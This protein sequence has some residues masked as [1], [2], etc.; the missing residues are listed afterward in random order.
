M[1]VFGKG[2][3]FGED[4]PGNRLV[5]HLSGCNMRCKWCSNPNGFSP[6]AG[7]RVSAEEML[8]E[9][10]SCK[11]MFFGG[12]GVTFTGGE[13]TLWHDELLPL[14]S[15]L[16]KE[17][18]HTALETNGTDERLFELL[19]YAD[20]L[21]MDFKHYDGE[22]LKAFTGMDNGAVKQNFAYNCANKIPQHIRI[23]LINGFNADGAEGFVAFFTKHDTSLTDFE[24][25]AYHEYGREK[26]QTEYE[27]KN[28]FITKEQ[29]AKF[30]ETFAKNGLK[31]IKS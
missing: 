11:P 19:P 24:F 20:Y 18:V 10:L 28:G 31:V 1:Y 13:A 27:L 12:G 16:K 14:L 7:K 3:N 5:Y 21:M 6:T 29:L 26:W 15:A 17:G 30:N 4:G 22:K 9:I 23:P 25:L 2:F 8:S